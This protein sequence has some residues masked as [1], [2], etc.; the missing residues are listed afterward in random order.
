MLLIALLFSDD[1]HGN[2]EQN[3][4]AYKTLFVTRI[5]YDTSESKLR[6]EFETYGPIRKVCDSVSMFVV[7]DD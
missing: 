7:C 2:A 4:D 5:N 6:R 3:S 1:P